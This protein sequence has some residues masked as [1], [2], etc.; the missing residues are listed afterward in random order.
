MIL[1]E[2]V[3]AVEG[4]DMV[5]MVVHV[6]IETSPTMKT[7]MATRKDLLPRVHLMMLMESLLK[8]VSVAMVD[9]VVHSVVAVEATTAMETLVKE[10]ETALAGRLSAAVELAAGMY[11]KCAILIVYVLLSMFF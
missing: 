11:E 8:G 1:L 6:P 2:E 4:V 3:G 10:N 5:A 9:L 7:T